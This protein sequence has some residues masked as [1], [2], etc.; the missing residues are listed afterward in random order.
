MKDNDNGRM[1]LVNNSTPDFYTLF[2]DQHLAE[3]IY[4]SISKEENSKV[5]KEE[6][7]LAFE[8]AN[9]RIASENVVAIKGKSVLVVEAGPT[10]THG[11]MAYGAGVI[12]ARRFGAARLVDP[13]PYLVGSI[14]ETFDSYPNIGT[15]LPAMGYGRR[16]MA[17]LQAT[18]NRTECDLVLLATPVDLT[19]LIEIDK[20]TVRIRYGYK[21]NSVPTLGDI[22][23]ERLAG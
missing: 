3:A 8:S 21:D 6:L 20:P 1:E 5:L 16:Q 13:R 10:L 11:E 14:K 22:I 4:P 17:D 18:I 2:I 9:A 19:R 23:R 15:L 12:A 7:E